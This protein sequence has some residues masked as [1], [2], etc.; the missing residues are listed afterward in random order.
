MDNSARQISEELLALEAELRRLHLW[1]SDAPT[2][3]ALASIH[4]YSS[5]TLSFPQWL[6]WILLP[7]IQLIV[8]QGGPYPLQSGIHAYAGEGANRH[9][10]DGLE[11]LRLGKRFDELIEQRRRAGRD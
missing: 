4:P 2:V 8:A 9:C 7:R 6:H 3:T 11:L 10:P 5:D 1:D